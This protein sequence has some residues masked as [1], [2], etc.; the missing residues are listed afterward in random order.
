M[1]RWWIAVALLGCQDQT[2]R[3]VN[4]APT[5]TILSPADGAAT[6]E[7]RPVT[8]VGEVRDLGTDAADLSVTWSSDVD[9]VLSREAPDEDGGTEVTTT[10]SR[11]AH[12]LTLAVVDPDGAS[13]E[14]TIGFT[15]T[16]DQPPALSIVAPTTA[17]AVR[18]GRPVDLVVQVD[19]AE[20]GPGDLEVWW[21]V[22]DEPL[23]DGV[24]VGADGRGSASA[25]L[26][27]GTRRLSAWVRD[28]AGQEVFREVAVDVGPRGTP[29]ACAFLAPAG[30]VDWAGPDALAFE[31]SATD[32]DDP[33]DQLTV[34]VSSDLDGDLVAGAPDGGGRLVGAVA[35]SRGVH[36]LTV[37]VTDLDGDVCTATREVTTS[38]PPTLTWTSPA[39]GA[40]VPQGEPV[41]VSLRVDDP[42]VPATDVSVTLTAPGSSTVVT[43]DAAGE[44]S[45][46]A[47]L[48]SGAQTVSAA[49]TDGLG[50]RATATLDLSVN[51]PATATG[52]PEVAPMPLSSS[53]TGQ[54]LAPGADDAEGD[55]VIW[56]V[57]WEVNG[58][59]VGDALPPD[60]T[61]P[62][63]V[64]RCLVTPDDGYDLGAAA[65][66]AAVT[67]QAAV[68][69]TPVVDLTPVDPRTTDDLVATLV[70]PGVDPDG[71]AVVHRWK[72][73]RGG[74]HEPAYNDLTTLPAT[75][76]TR[77]ERWT[78]AVAAEVL[79]VFSAIATD[80]V[81]VGNTPPV[82]TSV[83]LSPV[84]AYTGDTLVPDLEAL[85]PDGDSLSWSVGWEVDGVRVSTSSTLASGFHKHD[86]V[87][88]VASPFD[89]LDAGAELRSAPLTISNSPPGAPA[90][91]VSPSAPE[92]GVDDLRCSVTAPA[93]DADGDAL[94]YEVGWLVDGAPYP[95]SG[96]VGPATTSVADDT[97]PAADLTAGEVWTCF[98]QAFDDDLAGSTPGSDSVVVATPAAVRP[99]YDGVFELTT[100]VTYRCADIFFGIGVIQFT[101]RRFTFVDGPNL[102]V[103]GAPTAMTQAPAPS[104]ASFS[105]SGA[106][107]GGCTETYALTGSFSDADTWSGVYALT[108][109][110]GQCG[111]T[112]CTNQSWPVSATRQ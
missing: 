5:A 44:V 61:Q 93:D 90:V 73:Q 51:T 36:T 85:D 79:G 41:S 32:A 53:D 1:G 19:D 112:T 18:E 6:L 92:A 34:T 47:S 3:G 48:P 22:N 31:V 21:T 63:D 13:A 78:V 60:A 55:S 70:T 45:W 89:G 16:D 57:A 43:P 102:T 91:G 7:L 105:A 94:T 80:Q 88:A 10:L 100:P 37:A 82:A 38:V 25:T 20:D 96:D 87:V 69:S 97:V 99:D 71:G 67:V 56:V 42:D 98:V 17:S 59:I 84:P 65:P 111:L 12:R 74:V 9:G 23:V 50:F 101:T 35:L 75:A 28:S 15:V 40:R 76:T 103:T 72:W 39:S 30:T 108:L 27:E 106:L 33:A 11:G 66:S 83:T 14:A 54:C 86:V 104:D 26:T 29:P 77:G 81:V 24:L 58:T 62:G 109:T 46:T 4:E 8:L 68:P 52:V 110:G 95:R 64:V 2:L 107:P 49:A